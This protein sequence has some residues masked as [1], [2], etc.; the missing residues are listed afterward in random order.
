MDKHFVEKHTGE[1]YFSSDDIDSIQSVGEDFGNGDNILFT[2]DDEK[3]N[4]PFSSFCEYLTSGL[5]FNRE[6]LIKRLDLYHVDQ[7]GVYAAMFEVTCSMITDI[8]ESKC[9][10]NSLL[11]DGIIGTDMYI[12]LRK[13]L[14]ESLNR[15]VEFIRN[16]DKVA[17]AVNVE[18]KRQKRKLK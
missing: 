16:V 12:K 4:E 2:Y 5:V 7:I 9:M 10:I 14:D 18:N 8:N 6:E 3:D 17:L 11:D 13:Y 1:Y 15:Q